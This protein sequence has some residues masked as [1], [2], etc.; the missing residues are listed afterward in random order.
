M[1]LRQIL[2]FIVEV[3]SGVKSKSELD[4][5]FDIFDLVSSTGDQSSVLNID[6]LTSVIADFR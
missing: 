1:L 3:F 5:K 4:Y 6:D 2:Y